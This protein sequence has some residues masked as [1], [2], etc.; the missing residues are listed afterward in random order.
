MTLPQHVVTILCGMTATNL[1]FNVR[2]IEHKV[3]C[4]GVVDSY[5][6]K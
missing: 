2:I 1:L 4:L 6:A 5:L 3:G